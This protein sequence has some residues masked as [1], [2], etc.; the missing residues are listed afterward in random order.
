MDAVERH[1]ELRREPDSD[2]KSNDVR[3]HG[4]LDVL[5]PELPSL[6]D[7]CRHEVRLEIDPVLMELHHRGRR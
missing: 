4:Q 1:L 7:D 5:E 3:P 6:S 2:V